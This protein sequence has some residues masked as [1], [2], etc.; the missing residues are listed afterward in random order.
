MSHEFSH[1]VYGADPVV[2]HIL[3]ASAFAVHSRNR[4]ATHSVATLHRVLAHCIVLLASSPSEPARVL[5][6]MNHIMI[7]SHTLSAATAVPINPD[8]AEHLLGSTARRQLACACM[9]A[10]E[11]T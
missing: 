6:N 5:W 9:P 8:G 11:P 10:E 1:A 2:Q 3:H 7:G 4:S